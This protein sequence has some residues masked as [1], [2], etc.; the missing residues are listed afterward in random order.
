MPH[1]KAKLVT[2][3]A[4]YECYDAVRNMLHK[5]G[6]KAFSVSR[7]DGEGLHGPQHDGF[8][9]NANFVFTV[10]TT[11]A[12][13]ERILAWVDEHLVRQSFPA[14]AYVVDTE[15]VLADHAG[16]HG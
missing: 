2:V 1:V 14:I 10:V 7:S 8:V 3:I 13:A 4:A 16:H 15:A 5:K 9:G 12:H 6:I 11:E